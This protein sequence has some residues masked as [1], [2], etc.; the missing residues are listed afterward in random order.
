MKKVFIAVLGVFLSSSVFA[1]CPVGFVDNPVSGLCSSIGQVDF[2]NG[3]GP[4]NFEMDFSFPNSFDIN[5]V[6]LI[7]YFQ[8]W[9]YALPDISVWSTWYSV[10]YSGSVLSIVSAS[11]DIIVGPISYTPVPGSGG[12]GESAAALFTM[13]S[14]YITAGLA[15]LAVVCLLILGPRIFKWAAN[16]VYN[17]FGN[18]FLLY[19]ADRGRYYAENDITPG[20]NG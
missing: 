18:D 3:D 6:P 17:L 15:S 16:Q 5:S 13:P 20:L 8:S 4:V 12:G 2:L 9:G 1:L 19:Y 7:A 11:P 14:G 10:S